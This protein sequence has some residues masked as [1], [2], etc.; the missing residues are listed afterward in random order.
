MSAL[1]AMFAVTAFAL[2]TAAVGVVRG[3]TDGDR[4]VA[5]DLAFYAFIAAVA[6]LGTRLG[7]TS[8]FEVVLVA[9]LVGFLSSVSVARLIDRDDRE[10]DW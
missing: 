4:A 2:L 5:G 8:F 9:A 10:E 6:V 3:P 7:D 1:D